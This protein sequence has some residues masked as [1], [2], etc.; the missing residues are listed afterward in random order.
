M[1]N[2]RNEEIEAILREV[3]DIL[4]TNECSDIVSISLS[5]MKG[6]TPSISYEVKGKVVRFE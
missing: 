3:R 5:Y 1:E 6:Y 4:Y 2:R